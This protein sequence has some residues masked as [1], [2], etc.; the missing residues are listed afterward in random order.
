MELAT[1]L[2]LPNGGDLWH[3]L[4]DEGPCDPSLNLKMSAD[5]RKTVKLMMGKDNVRR[6]TVK[7]VLA[8]PALRDAERRRK[9]QLKVA[10]MVRAVVLCW[11]RIIW[12]F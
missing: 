11:V 8:M 12:E 2:D 5:L 10:E 7:Q 1:D 6:P 4:R 3:T 9:R